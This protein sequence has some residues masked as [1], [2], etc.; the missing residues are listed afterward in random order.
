MIPLLSA[1]STVGLLVC[2]GF[3]LFPGRLT[4]EQ[5]HRRDGWVVLLILGI[6]PDQSSPGWR[7]FAA[8]EVAVLGYCWANDRVRLNK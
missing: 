7:L 4:I 5:R 3:T 8:V 6:I 1:L 2:L